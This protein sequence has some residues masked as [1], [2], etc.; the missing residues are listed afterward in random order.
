MAKKERYWTEEKI[1]EYMK[2]IELKLGYVPSRDWFKGSFNFDKPNI[3]DVRRYGG[4]DK[5]IEK[6]NMLSECM[7]NK[8]VKSAWEINDTFDEV[9]R[10]K[11]E[12]G[13][14]PYV[15]EYNKNRKIGLAHTNIERRF[16]MTW[17]D[18]LIKYFE[19]PQ[20]MKYTL[21][22]NDIK[23]A[24][25]HLFEN[26]KNTILMKDVANHL[27]ISSTSIVYIL[28]GEPFCDILTELGIGLNKSSNMHKNKEDIIAEVKQFY[29]E[30]HRLPTTYELS[31]TLSFTYGTMIS[32]CGSLEN[33]CLEL[34]ID[35]I[36]KT[37][38]FGS[39]VYDDNG[40]MCRS[41][42]EQTISNFLINNNVQFRKEVPY[43]EIF[44]IDCKYRSDWFI[45]HNDRSYVVE[46]FG[47]LGKERYDKKTKIK[48]DIL[49]NNLDIATPILIS[50]KDF[51]N[52][53]DLF[54]IFKDIL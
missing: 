37:F 44:N 19:K 41:I 14:F 49:N 35:A 13:R 22:R 23:N 11:Q 52:E 43:S 4:F 38:G 10:M 33:I 25:L 7:Y 1:V 46:Y 21:S 9:I 53:A 51:K 32:K 12:L 27:N 40:E 54:N 18:F 39:L 3:E 17:N 16:N 48:T 6:Y 15:R 31:D 28:N 26:G 5:I 50:I 42:K 30:N 8:L 34:N 29:D 2:G 45:E 47:L 20:Y 24:V 36:R